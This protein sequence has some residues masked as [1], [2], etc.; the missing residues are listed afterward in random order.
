MANPISDDHREEVWEALSDAFVDNEVDYDSIAKVVADVNPI[1]LRE[2]FFTEVAPHCGPNL[3]SAVPPVWAGF[4][5]QALA[6]GIREMQTR[7]R[8]SLI[9]RLRHKT[10]VCYL[11]HRFH[12]EWHAIEAALG[13]RNVG[14]E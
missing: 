3:M 9:A 12:D 1:E 4:D 13:K 5:R 11:R 8:D 10:F 7:N 14:H 6:K 2:I